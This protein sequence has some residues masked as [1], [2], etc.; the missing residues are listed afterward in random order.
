MGALRV[1]VLAF[2]ETLRKRKAERFRFAAA[3]SIPGAS[4]FASL[5]NELI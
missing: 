1:F 5:Y 2:T 3:G 4:A